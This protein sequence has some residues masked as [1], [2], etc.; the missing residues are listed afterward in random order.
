MTDQN[1]AIVPCPNCADEFARLEAE[2]QR[3]RQD[4]AARREALRQIESR[5]DDLLRRH[6][7]GGSTDAA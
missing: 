4:D 2:L 3:L 6:E 7:Q 1:D 5:A